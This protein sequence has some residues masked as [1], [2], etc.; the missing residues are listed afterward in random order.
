M[1]W[2][3]LPKP[4]TKEQC[5]R[6]YVECDDDIGI[7]R[8]ADTSGQTKGSIER[9][10]SKEDWVGQRRRYRDTLRANTQNR[11]I[12]KTSEKLSDEL[13]D[14]AIANY[15]V[16][17]LIR[18]YGYAI[19]QLKAKHLSKIREM[20]EGDR[21]AELDKKHNSREMNAWGQMVARATQ[22]IAAAT[23]LPN[24]IN[25]DTAFKRIEMEG[26]VVLDPRETEGE[27]SNE[28]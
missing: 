25:V 21:L 26:Y 9:W 3:K 19:F 15:N 13:S 12:E 11:T 1:N 17:K 23:G 28:Q 18:D 20:P 6:R 10:S 14:V 22:E 4:W 5:R 7:R 24:Y 8:L 2:D 16:N 27:Q